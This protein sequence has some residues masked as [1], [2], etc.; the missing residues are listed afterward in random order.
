MGSE[1]ILC[2]SEISYCACRHKVLSDIV[3]LRESTPVFLSALKP[4]YFCTDDADEA[5]LI[6]IKIQ[7]PNFRSSPHANHRSILVLGHREAK[8]VDNVRS[9]YSLRNCDDDFLAGRRGILT[10]RH[11][12][13]SQAD[14]K[15]PLVQ[16][17]DRQVHV[18]ELAFL[19]NIRGKVAAS[20]LD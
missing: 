4:F 11:S 9:R 13:Q 5:F 1:T 20:D 14:R 16:R 7:I 18:A 3:S 19:Y 10:H 17:K 15:L 8:T 12:T 2:K 6:R